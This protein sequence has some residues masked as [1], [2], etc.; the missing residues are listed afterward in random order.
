MGVEFGNEVEFVFA[1]FG[2]VGEDEVCWI[3]GRL[4]DGLCRKG[5]RSGGGRWSEPGHVCRASLTTTRMCCG[6]SSILQAR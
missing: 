2:D 6:H 5:E 1:E 3:E 4:L